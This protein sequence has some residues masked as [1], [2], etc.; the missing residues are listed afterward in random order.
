M[1][2]FQSFPRHALFLLALLASH[3]VTLCRPSGSDT[4]WGSRISS[5]FSKSPAN[6][7]VTPTEKMSSHAS[8]TSTSTTTSPSTE[9]TIQKRSDETTTEVTS[10]SAS[11][12]PTVGGREK[13]EVDVQLANSSSTLPV[14]LTADADTQTVI[15]TKNLSRT[16]NKSLD[17]HGAV[18]GEET[19]VTSP[20]QPGTLTEILMHSSTTA[21]IDLPAVQEKAS[22][23]EAALSTSG[24]L[25]SPTEGS[26][27]VGTISLIDESTTSKSS[28][29]GNER[30]KSSLSRG[31]NRK[32]RLPTTLKP[33]KRKSVAKNTNSSIEDATKS[34]V[35]HQN[36]PPWNFGPSVDP[37][38]RAKKISSDSVVKKVPP[39]STSLNKK[40]REMPY[41]TVFF[42]KFGPN[43]KEA[44]KQ[45]GAAWEYHAYLLGTLFALLGTF[46]LISL[47]HLRWSDRLLNKTYLVA[48]DIMILVAASCRSVF[49]L[50][51]P[52]DVTGK[53][54][55]VTAYLLFNIAYPSLSSACSV[56]FLALLNTTKVNLLPQ[57]VQRPSILAT[58]VVF[59]F[60][61]SIASDIVVGF[62]SKPITLILACQVFFLM[63]TFLLSIAYFY[64]FQ[65][66]FKAALRKQ[67]EMIR[68]T[69]TKLHIDGAELP[70]RLPRPTLA[71]SVKVA[72]ITAVL[73]LVMTVLQTYGLVS[74]YRVP[75]QLKPDYW[76]WWGFHFASRILEIAMCVTM[77]YIASQPTKHHENSDDTTPS[78][79]NPCN[80]FRRNRNKDVPD[81][82]TYANQYAAQYGFRNENFN[83]SLDSSRPWDPLGPELTQSFQN[84]GAILAAERNDD[85][86]A[87]TN[88]PRPSIVQS[89]STVSH[90]LLSAKQSRSGNPSTSTDGR[91]TTLKTVGTLTSVSEGGRSTTSSRPQSMLFKEKGFIRFRKDDDPEQPLDVTDEEEEEES[92]SLRAHMGSSIHTLCDDEDTA[93]DC[94]SPFFHGCMNQALAKGMS[95]CSLETTDLSSDQLSNVTRNDGL[96]GS[97][98]LD[99]QGSRR[100]GSTCSSESAANSF[101]VAFY[102]GA[103]ARHPF[104]CPHHNLQEDTRLRTRHDKICA[105]SVSPIICRTAARR[106]CDPHHMKLNLTHGHTSPGVVNASCGT[107]DITPDSAVYLDLHLSP[108]DVGQPNFSQEQPLLTSSFRRRSSISHSLNDLNRTS[109]QSSGSSTRSRKASSRGFLN[110]LRGSTF[111]LNASL[112]GYEPLESD[113]CSTY[114]CGASLGKETKVRIKR[115]CSDVR[116]RSALETRMAQKRALIGE[117]CHGDSGMLDAADQTQRVDGCSQTDPCVI[118]DTCGDVAGVKERIVP[119][120]V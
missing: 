9:Y 108:D 104:C 62:F 85:N 88:I 5:W 23:V 97:A 80:A 120:E 90:S 75:P 49:L 39:L 32:N 110:R 46:S 54:H 112:N 72:L 30:R 98:V 69:F 1:R 87:M 76:C 56:M 66:L 82:E 95:G 109:A 79:W 91:S 113:E 45:W 119:I 83:T 14:N 43:L 20:T 34:P 19:A 94:L 86:V 6:K 116:P 118:S 26:A 24:R 13:T 16:A 10:K 17:C 36:D 77:L 15:S 51:D 106:F 81:F 73:A 105:R 93:Q 65:Q 74:I 59:H 99:F 115:S 33:D 70:R 31:R 22:T 84:P 8:T 58:V 12:V 96:S 42:W 67:S 89:N 47:I 50:Y 48:I 111:S 11:A 18:C 27:T 2:G 28:R 7:E 35:T 53:Y 103:N 61:F 71:T 68:L 60:C 4:A 21:A 52:Y 41:G 44:K 57:K 100:F 3:D 37:D 102:L 40:Y 63:W 101:D 114:F 29:G 78:Y 64:V 55:P 92:D 38:D 25:T 117:L 107:E